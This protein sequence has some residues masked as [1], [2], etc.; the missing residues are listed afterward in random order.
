[1]ENNAKPNFNHELNTEVT[2]K[3]SGEK[4]VISGR[5]EYH[6]GSRTYFVA[7]VDGNGCFKEAWI[8]QRDLVARHD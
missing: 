8:D 2:I 6:T 7:Y 4:G 5:C 3:S 1:M